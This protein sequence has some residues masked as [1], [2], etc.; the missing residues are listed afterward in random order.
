LLRNHEGKYFSDVTTAS[1]T[2]ELHK[3][4]GVAFADID[5][6]GD[7]DIL[8]LTG[9]AVP[10]DSHQFRLFENP[11]YGNDW[12]NL[13]LVGV[14]SNRGA[15]GARIKIT[16]EGAGQS[17]RDIYRTVT[18]GGSFGASPL[19]QHMGLGRSAKILN[20]EVWWPTSNAR[21]NF[22]NVQKDQ[23]L[24]I[25]EFATEFTKLERRAVKLGGKTA[26]TQ[27]NPDSHAA[28]R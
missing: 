2:G 8:T 20:I 27:N 24:E 17:P 19:E 5:R 12:I 13:K 11:G 18:S 1:G 22:K 3:G 23:F 6:D 7:E 26:S 28:S 16:V 10:G 4:H 9:G 21:Q 25:K 15:V 14:K